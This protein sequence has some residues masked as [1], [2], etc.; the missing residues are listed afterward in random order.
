MVITDKLKRIETLNIN[1]IIDEA[2]KEVENFILDLNREQL[3][4]KG[5]IDVTRPGLKEHYAEGTIRQ[6][7]KKAKFKKTEFVTLRWEGDFYDSFQL[8]IF[9]EKFIIQAKD[10]KWSN[11]L[12]PNP[13]FGKALGL[14]EESK[15]LLI[16]KIRPII[17]QRIRNVI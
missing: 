11:W 10:L 3:Y 14:T 2:L 1:R 12:E 9:K 4:E 15:E 17:I 6:K 8:I 5:E 16:N 7:R 13:R